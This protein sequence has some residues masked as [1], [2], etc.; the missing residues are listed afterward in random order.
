MIRKYLFVLIL[1]FLSFACF[2]SKDIK[3]KDEKIKEIH[4][5][6]YE[7]YPGTYIVPENYI[8]LFANSAKYIGKITIDVVTGNTQY[9]CLEEKECLFLSHSFNKIYENGFDWTISYNKRP[10]KRKDTD[11]IQENRVFNYWVRKTNVSFSDKDF[12]D[13]LENLGFNFGNWE[14]RFFDSEL[15]QEYFSNQKMPNKTELVNFTQLAIYDVIGAKEDGEIK[16]YRERHPPSS[17]F[18]PPR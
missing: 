2:G 16:E 6:K 13:I 9:Y 8:L 5:I 18:I 10:A 3:M 15:G 7:R 1:S 4:I 12:F 14:Y 17:Y 11:I